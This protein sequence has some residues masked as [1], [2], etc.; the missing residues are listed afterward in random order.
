MAAIPYVCKIL[1]RKYIA[2][3]I[4][5]KSVKKAATRLQNTQPMLNLSTKKQLA[6]PLR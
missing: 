2:C 1:D 6:M 5:Y 4:N 3:E